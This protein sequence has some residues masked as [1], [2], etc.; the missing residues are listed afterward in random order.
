MPLPSALSS[1]TFW[2]WNQP[3]KATRPAPE[4]PPEDTLKR[5]KAPFS[6]SA[7]TARPSACFAT[8]SATLAVSSEELCIISMFWSMS[9]VDFVVASMPEAISRLD[10]ACSS[11]ESP[12][13]IPYR[14]SPDFCYTGVDEACII[15]KRGEGLGPKGKSHSANTKTRTAENHAMTTCSGRTCWPASSSPCSSPFCPTWPR[16]LTINGTL[17]FSIRSCVA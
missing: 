1:Y 4:A 3:F 15:T 17:S 12:S 6:L 11:T 9:T 13:D 8:S 2:L 7:R 14:N 16:I 5:D 10:A